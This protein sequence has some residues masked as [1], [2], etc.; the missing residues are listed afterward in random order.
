MPIL[1]LTYALLATALVA[2]VLRAG[3]P[4]GALVVVVLGVALR[5]RAEGLLDRPV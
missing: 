1:R 3:L 4:L 2:W 5:R